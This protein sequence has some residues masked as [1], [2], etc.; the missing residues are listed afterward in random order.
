MRKSLSFWILIFLWACQEKEELP[1]D[2]GHDYTPLGVDRFWVYKVNETVYFGEED[3]ETTTFFYRDVVTD[4]Y[5]GNHG[6]LVYVVNRQKST[7][8]SEWKN[9]LVYSLQIRNNALLRTMDN[10]Q[11]VVLVFPPEDHK[12]WDGNIYNNS[13]VDEFEMNLLS[14]YGLEGKLYQSAS[15]VI[16]EDDDDGITVR[17]KRFE[18][19]ARGVGLVEHYSEVLT[20]CSR[21]DCL[22]EQIIDSGRFIHL[23]LIDNGQF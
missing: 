23:K 13:S 8:Q 10:E 22:G 18:V 9:D 7:T 19:Y 11:L 3:S 6:G 12:R 17:N 1:T 4:S 14:G 21:N 16:Q 20:Y 5:I 2:L 15:Q